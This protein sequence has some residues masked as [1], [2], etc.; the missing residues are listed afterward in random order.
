MT[1]PMIGSPRKIVGI[2]LRG[3]SPARWFDQATSI[4]G[5]SFDVLF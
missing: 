3:R 4:V 1:A 5:Q 2:R